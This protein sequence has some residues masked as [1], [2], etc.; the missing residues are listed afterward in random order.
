MSLAEPNRIELNLLN[1][2][3]LFNSMDPSPF[4]ERDLDD[5]AEEFIVSWARE[6]PMHL[7]MKLVVH[8][9]EPCDEAAK[10][11]V[12]ESIHHYFEYKADLNRRE[13][14][15]LMRQGWISLV[16]GL[17]F[18]IACTVGSE[19]LAPRFGRFQGIFHEGLIIIG[20]VA[21]WHPLEIYLYLWWPVLE[22][23][24]VYRKLSTIPIEVNMGGGRL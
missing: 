11:L 12:A 21:M 4:R 8:V 2:K 16:I 15:R 14:R 23:G 5:D 20:W 9:Q 17:G 18:L 24:K 1:V 7:P 22:L 10:Q 6:H 3:Q 13:F 19:M